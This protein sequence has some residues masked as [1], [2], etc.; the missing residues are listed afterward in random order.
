MQPPIEFAAPECVRLS[1]TVDVAFDKELV[2][3]LLMLHET[4]SLLQALTALS[5]ANKAGLVEVVRKAGTG[6]SSA[7]FTYLHVGNDPKF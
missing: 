2:R 1:V 6:G 3:S 4:P 7:S 5:Q